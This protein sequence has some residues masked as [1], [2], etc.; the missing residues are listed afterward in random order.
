MVF[1]NM[2]L[3]VEVQLQ[4][5]ILDKKSVM[6]FIRDAS[7][8]VLRTGGGEPNLVLCLR[9]LYIFAHV[10]HRSKVDYCGFLLAY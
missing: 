5:E 4:P 9:V 8:S 6:S 2:Y 1:S 7:G 3:N 10:A